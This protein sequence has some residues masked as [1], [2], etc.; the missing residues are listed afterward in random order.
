MSQ[1][2]QPLVF[3]LKLLIT[4]IPCYF[5]WNNIISTPGMDSGDFRDLITSIHIWPL[6]IALLCLALSTLSGCIQ[7]RLLL[8]KQNIEM[9]TPKL[10]K[11]YY[12]GLFF[13]NFMPG[14]V[15]GDL[16][17]IYDIRVGS[18]ES[19]G[20]AVS[21]TVFD[22]L[23]GLYFLNV[24]ALIVG[25]LF[26][27]HDPEQRYFLIPSFWVFIGFT[28]FQIALF[29]RRLSHLISIIAA[30]ILPKKL[31]NRFC[32]LQE[33]FHAF[34]D[35][36][37]WA[38]ITFLSGLTQTLRVLVHFFCGIAIGLDIAVSWY[39]FYIPMIAVISALPISIGGFGPRELLAQS[40]FAKAGVAAMD[41][42]VVQLLA[43]LTGLLLSLLGAFEFLRKRRKPNINKSKS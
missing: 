26:F 10:L 8:K 11:I 43:Y 13:N 7:W 28:I 35:V 17:K 37:L 6:F 27:I 15:G 39:F 9:S 2:R 16:K 18:E 1:V 3:L 24:L 32:H 34:R 42:V 40:L 25:A 30:K 4:I 14:N 29:S 38:S 31:G 5:V 36:K 33:R 21:A 12:V 41:S 20:A 23:F 19:V 22:R